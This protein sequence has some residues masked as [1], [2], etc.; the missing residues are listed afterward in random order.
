VATHIDI[1]ATDEQARVLGA[2][3]DPVRLRFVNELRS[4]QEATG[5]EIAERIG[6]SL[7]L[8]CHHSRIL[9]ESGLVQKEKRGQTAYF[10]LNKKLL[11]TTLKALLD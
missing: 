7:A 3:A 4:G 9:Q 5:T 2:L 6:I 10:T 1:V 11:R 8:L